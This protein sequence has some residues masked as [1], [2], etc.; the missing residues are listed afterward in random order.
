MGK[1]IAALS[2]KIGGYG[3]MCTSSGGLQKES[4]VQGHRRD[5]NKPPAQSD[6]S[7]VIRTLTL[8]RF[9][10]RMI[11]L[12]LYRHLH[13]LGLWLALIGLSACDGPSPHFMGI[14]PVRVEVEGSVFAVRV[15][16]NLAEAVRVNTQYAPR[17]G[18]IGTRAAKA[19]RQ[20]SG[21]EVREIRG[22]QALILGVLDC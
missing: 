14:E 21:C 5:V 9:D 16:G 18:P 2:G 7:A 15:K 11:Q 19:M 3:H 12:F 8:V 17:M 6:S 10:R 4:K 22:D 13:I 20:V 1:I